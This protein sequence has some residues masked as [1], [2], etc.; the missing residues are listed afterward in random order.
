M[1]N[2]NIPVRRVVTDVGERS[3]TKQAF[4]AEADAKTIVR[5]YKQSGDW[6]MLLQNRATPRYGDFTAATDYL[7][8]LT[9]VREAERLFM[10]L[11]SSVRSHVHNNVAEL[12]QLVY[13]PSRRDEAVKIG[14][15][16]E[17]T[18]DVEGSDG[19][20]GGSAAAGG[21]GTGSAS[22]AAGSAASGVAG[23]ASAQGVGGK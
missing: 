12:L 1:P 15:I 6:H 18:R 10:E 9:K 16:P 14:L 3:R 8:A 2:E 17:E 13:D 7:T 22:V 4:A 21:G 11:P 20:S 23:G 5:K 19:D